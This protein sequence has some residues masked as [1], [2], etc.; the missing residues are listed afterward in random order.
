MTHQRFALLDEIVYGLKFDR[1]LVESVLED[2][3]DQMCG[4]SDSERVV[5]ATKIMSFCYFLLDEDT[6]AF[7]EGLEGAASPLSCQS[8][9]QLIKEKKELDPSW[10]GTFTNGRPLVNSFRD[11]RMTRKITLWNG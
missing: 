2:H 10:S 8:K 4:A 1:K 5:P 9:N 11:G 7:T 3:V 6:C